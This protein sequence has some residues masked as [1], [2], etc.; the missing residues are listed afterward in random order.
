MRTIQNLLAGATCTSPSY[1]GKLSNGEARESFRSS[2]ESRAGDPTTPTE[3]IE[4]IGGWVAEPS[5]T[6]YSLR[7]R[8]NRALDGA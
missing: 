6:E 3:M 2:A 5:C 4:A 1:M 7:P 8:S